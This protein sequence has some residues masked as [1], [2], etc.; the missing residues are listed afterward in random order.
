[1]QNTGELVN[2]VQRKVNSA[3]SFA[4]AKQP[5][6]PAPHAPRFAPSLWQDEEDD[7]QAALYAS[8]PRSAGSDAH[9]GGDSSCAPFDFDGADLDDVNPELQRTLEG[10]YDTRAHSN[11]AQCAKTSA[12]SSSVE[13]PWR[14]IRAWRR[15]RP[16]ACGERVPSH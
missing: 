2:Q 7:E 16:R 9:A 8:L 15:Q 3:G 14:A 1:M 12:R 4:M 10:A 13:T 11:A 5:T 6:A